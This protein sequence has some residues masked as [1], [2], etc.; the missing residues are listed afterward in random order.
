MTR[1]A[2]VRPLFFERFDLWTEYIMT[3][4]EHSRYSCVYLL[5]KF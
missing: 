4:L 5:S 1:I 3:T 2:K